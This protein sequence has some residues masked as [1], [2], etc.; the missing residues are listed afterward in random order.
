MK[1]SVYTFM[2]SEKLPVGARALIQLPPTN[3][4]LLE[5]SRVEYQ[6]FRL[7]YLTMTQ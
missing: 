1:I 3:L 2:C 6:L 4:S 7:V 5:L